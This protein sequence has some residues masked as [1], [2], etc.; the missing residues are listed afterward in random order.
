MWKLACGTNTLLNTPVRDYLL[1]IYPFK[2]AHIRIQQKLTDSFTPLTNRL[3]KKRCKIDFS[4][5]MT[6][7]TLCANLMTN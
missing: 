2:R 5:P 3:P 4:S 7:I 1:D 6:L